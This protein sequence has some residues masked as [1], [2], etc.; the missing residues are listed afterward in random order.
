LFS[1]AKLARPA[2]AGVLRIV[3]GFVVVGWV[4]LKALGQTAVELSKFLVRC[5][6]DPRGTRRR[7]RWTKIRIGISVWV[8]QFFTA[9]VARDLYDG[10]PVI[11]VNYL[12][13]DLAAHAFGPQDGVAFRALEFVDRSIGQI[14]RILRRMPEHEYDLFVLAD[15]GQTAS[16]PFANLTGGTPFE[17]LLFDEVIDIGGAHSDPHPATKG[18]NAEFAHGFMAY[19]IGRAG[20]GR[21]VMQRIDR[22]FTRCIDTREGLQRGPIRVIS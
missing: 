21:R 17:R 6:A 13:Y 16:T 8:R 1:V 14:D 20:M 2:G 12:D 9:A 22:E 19:Q 18:K 5:L 4:A 3:S 7:W 15:H 10:I 11:Y